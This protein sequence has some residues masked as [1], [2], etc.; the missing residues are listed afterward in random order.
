[1]EVARESC[2]NNDQQACKDME[3]AP[4]SALSDEAMV[5][6]GFWQFFVGI[7]G[8]YLVAATLKAT[9][10][11]VREAG[12]ATDAA[13]E[14]V[15]VTR[16]GM[17]IQ[18][19]A[20]VGFESIGLEDTPE[21]KQLFLVWI[22]RGQTPARRVEYA[23]NLV[24]EPYAL[25]V[26]YDFPDIAPVTLLNFSLGTGRDLPLAVAVTEAEIRRCRPGVQRAFLYAWI[27]YDD[28]FPDTPRHRS[29]MAYEM[30]AKVVGENVGLRLIPVPAFNGEDDSCFRKAK[31]RQRT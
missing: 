21:G 18:L 7:A 26:G 20:Y 6:L 28:V 13:K 23:S 5:D 9:R 10:D 25:P 30:I 4:R 29:E 3:S 12:D 2:A 16:V 24:F 27:E 1:M 22:N 15:A 11:A 14:A 17:E 31:D 19:R 8:V